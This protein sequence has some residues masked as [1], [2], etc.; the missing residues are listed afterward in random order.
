MENKTYYLFVI[1]LKAVTEQIY[2]T[3]DEKEYNV[4]YVVRMQTFLRKLIPL[5]RAREKEYYLYR[6]RDLDCCWIENKILLLIP[7]KTENDAKAFTFYLSHY[8]PNYD[9]DIYFE[10]RTKAEV[11][12]YSNVFD[13]YLQEE[14]T[15]DAILEESA[16]SK[17]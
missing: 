10:C 13:F 1:E 6:N 14:S 17:D 16:N 11:N 12:E 4:Y 9:Y 15:L 7:C 3:I 8:M 2:S 5:V